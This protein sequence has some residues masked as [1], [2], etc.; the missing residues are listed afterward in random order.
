MNRSDNNKYKSL[1]A[2]G[3]NGDTTLTTIKGEPSHVNIWEKH[4]SNTYGDLG[5][6]LVQQWGAGTTN[7]E[8]GMK[9]Y[10]GHDGGVGFAL[11][12]GYTG[13][14]IDFSINDGTDNG[15]NLNNDWENI[16]EPITT[17]A[18]DNSNPY[19]LTD[20][21][22]ES[23]WNSTENA[24]NIMAG[25]WDFLMGEEG[26]PGYLHDVYS[27]EQSKVQIG[28]DKIGEGYN[29]LGV[30]ED[31]VNQDNIYKSGLYDNQYD[32]TVTRG[33]G[34]ESART[35]GL[36]NVGGKGMSAVM[37]MNQADSQKNAA[38]GFASS[39]SGG[40]DY[41]RKRALKNVQTNVR[42]VGTT[43]QR[44][45]S[46]VRSD[47]AGISLGRDNLASITDSKLESLGYDRNL[48]DLSVDQLGI[49][50]VE[51]WMAYNKSVADATSGMLMEMNSI[52]GEYQ[53][54]TGEDVG[55]M[56][57]F[58]ISSWDS[59]QADGQWS[60]DDDDNTT[61]PLDDDD[62]EDPFTGETNDE[63]CEGVT[64]DPGEYCI[65]GICY[66]PDDIPEPFN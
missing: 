7:P 43:A 3:R 10:W 6:D 59:Y 35:S 66:A 26:D 57:Q 55:D 22:L 2:S 13:D 28:M 44:G 45:L 40:T 65:G 20:S 21:Q 63:L 53:M 49:A 33:K 15:I 31:L 34:I 42:E 24:G 46:D 52:T 30:Q 29:K 11:P 1:A 51:N 47:Q 9:E 50:G 56:D 39:S 32:K 14:N 60:F 17:D 27:I 41:E 8:T 12:G 37:G 19:G 64:C 54:T 23:A 48:L 16:N 36:S 4:V 62:D 18:P 58:D 5:D 61:P 25:Q 38:S